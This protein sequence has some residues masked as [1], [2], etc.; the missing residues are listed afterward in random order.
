MFKRLS[1][2][3]VCL[4]L[5]LSFSFLPQVMA[6][7]VPYGGWLDSIVTVE[8]EST[9]AA[10]RQLS[11]GALDVYADTITEVDIYNRIMEDPLIQYDRSYGSYNELSFNPAGPVFAET[12]ELNPFAVPRV[13]EA[14]NWLID[15]DY[16]ASEIFGGMAVPRLFPI[17]SAFPDYARLIEKVREMEV[18]YAYNPERAEAVISEEMV[19][20]GA[21]LID[22]V[23]HYDGSPVEIKILIRTEDERLE[24]G[25]YV[26]SMLERIGFRTHRQYA[27]AAEASPVWMSGNPEDGL[28]HVYTGGWVTTIV[29]RD[30][31]T[32]WDFFYT[33]RGLASPLWQAYE[34][35]PEFDEVANRLAIRDFSTMGERQEMMIEAMELGLEDSTRIWLVDRLAVNPYRTDVQLTADLAGG[36]SGSWLWA[37]TARKVDEVGGELRLGL[38][39]VMPEPWNPL[40]GSNWVFDMMLIRSTA[41]MGYQWDPYTGLHYPNRF[42]TATVKIEEGLPVDK[43]LDWVDL[44]FVE[45]GTEVPG[46]AWADW[47]AEEQRF[48]TVNEKY[49]DGV[50]ARRAVTTVYPEDFLEKTYWHDGSQFSAADIVWWFLNYYS[51]DRAAEESEFHDPA[52]VPEYESFMDHFRGFRITDMD[53]L[54]VE[55]YSDLFYLDAEWYIFSGYPYYDQ[56]P[57]A[58]HNLAVSYLAEVN[59]ELA[60][61]SSRADALDVDQLNL[62]GGPSLDILNRHLDRAM[63]EGILPYENVMSEFVSEEEMQER[64]ENL[65]SW[66][67]DRGHFWLGTGPYYLRRGH[68]VEGIV[69]L[70][71]N[72]D[73]PYPADRWDMFVE[74]MIPEVALSGP[75]SIR[76]G[77]EAVFDIRVM[78]DDE[79]YAHEDLTAVTALVFDEADSLVATVE[80]EMVSPGE[81]RAVLDEEITEKLRFG[82]TTVEVVVTSRLVASPV[83]ESTRV[84]TFGQ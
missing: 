6:E 8:E 80:A 21:E 62:I 40:D 4:A 33:P 44:E 84:V 58:W 57:G 66:Y 5:L 82:S 78:L 55:Y 27:T 54:T 75:G 22:G 68:P 41:D 3:T 47:D 29:A 76:I 49:P 17:T 38:P 71:R 35:S 64:Y 31:A 50:S 2:I 25:D 53:P 81:Y 16:M 9:S 30:Q 11:T 12:G 69:H 23:W 61:S 65:K 24:V 56:G 48:I 37:Y 34:P 39:S 67:Q 32:N 13:R 15:R 28:F 19:A 10:I 7:D 83:L 26:A 42:E 20:L 73:Y 46:D 52:K 72:E 59:E 79:P 51:F 77:S 45:G 36:I 1:I 18:E 43:T 60:L 14:M 70:G 74:P 63:E